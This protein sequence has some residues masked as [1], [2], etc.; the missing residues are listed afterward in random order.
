M[1]LS[2]WTILRPGPIMPAHEEEP[3]SGQIRAQCPPFEAQERPLADRPRQEGWVVVE[4][5]R[6][7]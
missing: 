5:Y 4:L 7:P 3:R 2:L 6:H 1:H